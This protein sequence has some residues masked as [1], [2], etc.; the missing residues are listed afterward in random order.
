LGDLLH[1]G[2][3]FSLSCSRVLDMLTLLIGVCSPP[4]FF[5]IPKGMSGTPLGS[6]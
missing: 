2:V 1:R 5:P 6:G 4:R 3:N